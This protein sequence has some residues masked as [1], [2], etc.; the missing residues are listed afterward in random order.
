MTSNGPCSSK[1]SGVDDLVRAELGD[2][3]AQPRVADGRGDVRAGGARR[4]GP[5]RCRRRRPRRGRAGARPARSPAWVKTASWAVVKT[6]GSAARLGPVER[7]GHRHRLALVD[8]RE[9]G[10]PAAADDRH[11]A[12]ALARSASR[13]GRAPTTSPAS[14]SP[15]MSGGEPGGAGYM[16]RRCIMSAPLSPAARTRTRTSPRPGSGSGWSSTTELLVA[17]RDGAHGAAVK[18]LGAGGRGLGRDAVALAAMTLPDSTY[19][20]EGISPR[21]FQHPADRAATAAL[22]QVPYLDARRPAAHRA[23]LRAR[24]APGDA[25]LGGAA[26]PGAAAAHLGARARGLPRRSTSRT[27][28]TST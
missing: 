27:S 23:R 11:D 25:R 4:A 26:R 12:V 24:A 1:P 10:L 16:P 14:S 18:H 19:Q 28:R 13:P 8:G 6:S 17:D 9:L 3:V 2:G 15:G 7:V 22:K 5:P 20:L 21:A